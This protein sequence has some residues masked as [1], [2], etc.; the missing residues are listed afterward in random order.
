MCPLKS[1]SLCWRTDPSTKTY[2]NNYDSFQ[3]KHKNRLQYKTK[4]NDKNHN[5]GCGICIL[6]HDKTQCLMVFQRHAQKWSFPK[7]SKQWGESN[8]YCMKRELYEETGLHLD[9]LQ[10]SLI[11]VV[12]RYHYYLAIIQL[13]KK[14]PSIILNPQDTTEIENVKWININEAPL[15]KMNRITEDVIHSLFY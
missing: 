2:N 8:I 7:G 10:F 11:N 14:Y 4:K 5:I 13:K 12:Y 15:L 6:S 9:R 3:T 1:E